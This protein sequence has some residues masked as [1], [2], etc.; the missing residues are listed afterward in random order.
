MDENSAIIEAILREDEEESR[1]EKRISNGK[2]DVYGWK[3][4]SY[5]KRQRKPS[6]PSSEA[7]TA[8]GRSDGVVAAG[9]NVFRS[10]EVQSEERRRR[11]LDAQ[12]AAAAAASEPV[13]AG[14]KRHSDDDEDSDREVNAVQNGGGVDSKKVKVKK[15]KKPKV[16]VAEAASKIDLDDLRAFLADI[17]VSDWLIRILCLFQLIFQFSFVFCEFLIG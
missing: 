2:D 14:S 5:Q 16:T 3:T 12:F 9:D 17:T 15:L 7:V 6:K 11:V 8:N 4:V 10:I 1:K 13:A